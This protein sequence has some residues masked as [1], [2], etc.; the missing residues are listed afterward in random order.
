MNFKFI[1]YLF[2]Y[3]LYIYIYFFVESYVSEIVVED[4]EKKKL[5]WT[6]WTTIFEKTFYSLKQK[7]KK[8]CLIIKNY[9][10]FNVLKNRKQDKHYLVV[11]NYFLRAI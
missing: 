1:F 10:L 5:L 8:I 6:C 11:F 3:F 7:T 9:F 2:L 4:E